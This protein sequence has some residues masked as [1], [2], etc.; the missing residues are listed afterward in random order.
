MRARRHVLPALLLCAAAVTACMAAERPPTREEAARQLDAD[1]GHLLGNA[2]LRLSAPD[3]RDDH[4]CV[5]GKV[6]HSVRAESDLPEVSDGLL[7]RLRAMGYDRVADDPDLRDDDQDVAVLR[8][9]RT[10]VEFELTVRSGDRPGVRVVGR[11]SCYA[12][13]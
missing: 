8:H 3:R 13:G 4:A 10:W 6:R 5:P 11:T 12:T 1:A 7:R 2:G 9:P